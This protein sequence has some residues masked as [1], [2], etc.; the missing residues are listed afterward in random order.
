MHLDHAG[1]LGDFPTATVH[2]LAEELEAFLHPRSVR[3]WAPYRP[4]HRSHGPKWRP[5]T[6]QGNLWFG[7]DCTQPIRVGEAE[8][9]MIPL[10]GHTRGHC[11]VALWVGDRW[12]M[13]CGDAYGYYGQVD[14]AKPYAF[15]G[16]KLMEIV[17]MTGFRIPKRHRARIMELVQ[18]HGDEV[19]TFCAHDAFEFTRCE[20][21]HWGR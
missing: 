19:E 13:H 17:L 8:F 21:G 16:G 9:V 1:G 11:A 6:L 2:I 12:L 15:P 4:E 10:T 14:P 20:S 18:M 5:H 7:L 3:E